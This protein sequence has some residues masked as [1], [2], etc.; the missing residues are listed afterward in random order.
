[1]GVKKQH[2]FTIIEVMLFLAITGALAVAILV[3]SGTAIGQQRYRDSVNSFKGFIQQQYNDTTNVVNS[4]ANNSA[5]TDAVVAEP[6][7]SVPSPQPRGTSECVIMGRLLTVASNGSDVTAS[8]IVGYRASPTAPAAATDLLELR[9][10]YKLGVSLIDTDTEQI[11]WGSTVVK[12]KTTE[13]EALSIMIIRSPLSGTVMTFIPTE[14]Q[15]DPNV[16]KA[17]NIVTTN[18]DICIDADAGSFAGSRQAIRINAY[19][20]SANAIEIPS[21]G[22]KACDN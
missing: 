10:N 9:T 5:C 22:D 12:P 17:G 16:I 1:M 21:E 4:R 7:E 14:N 18:R 2:G 8:N 15:T 11:R 13:I 20:S 19:A 6:P 3:G